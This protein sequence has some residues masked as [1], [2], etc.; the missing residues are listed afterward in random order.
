MSELVKSLQVRN[1]TLTSGKNGLINLI[2]CACDR[3]KREKVCYMYYIVRFLHTCKVLLNINLNFFLH[4][5]R[6]YLRLKYL[7]R[8]K[9]Y[10]LRRI[11]T[12]GLEVKV[13]INAIIFVCT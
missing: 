12:I 11:H 9:K 7:K 6:L 10:K 1:V 2:Q 3:D 13:T 8:N 4:A 5:K